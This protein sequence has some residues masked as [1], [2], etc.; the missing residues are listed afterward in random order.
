MRTVSLDTRVAFLRESDYRYGKGLAL[1]GIRPFSCI[2]GLDM[3][4]VSFPGFKIEFMQRDVVEVETA[5]S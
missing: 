2:P 4:T 5:F 1:E 3:N